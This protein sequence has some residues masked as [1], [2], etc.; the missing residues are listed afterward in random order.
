MHTRTVRVDAYRRDD[1]QWDLEA[2][3]VD[4][5]PHDTPLHSG[6]RKGGEAVHAMRLRVTIDDEFNVVDAVAASDSVPYPGYC[7]AIVGDYRKLVGLNLMRGFRS[8]LRERLGERHGCTHLTELAQSLPTAA[9]QSFAGDPRRY[10]EMERQTNGHGPRPF[11][12]D[13]CH[14]LR[15]DGPAIARYYPAWF[16]SAKPTDAPG[17][18]ADSADQPTRV[19]DERAPVGERAHGSHERPRVPADRP[20]ATAT[21]DPAASTKERP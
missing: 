18:R 8:A 13:R 4:M 10:E 21:P 2:E 17:E 12:I 15:S 3:L 16:R 5:K 7:E 9:I 1:G 19:F 11:Q 14:A 20:R 6:V